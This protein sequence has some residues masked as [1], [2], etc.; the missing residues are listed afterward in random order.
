MAGFTHESTKNESVEWYTPPEIFE[1]LDTVFDMDPCSPGEGLSFVPAKKHLTII[2]DGLTSPWEGRVFMNPPYG[3]ETKRWMKRFTEHGNGIALVFARTDVAWFQ[4]NADHFDG[5]LFINGRVRF[6]KG[7]KDSR[8][9]TPGA[10]SM[11]VACGEDNARI[12]QESGLGVFV[13]VENGEV[14]F[15]DWGAK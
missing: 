15:A 3:N 14:T 7:S 10:G 11:L 5:I 4:D 13:R 2:N 1:S 6:Y 9:G 12:L 8:G